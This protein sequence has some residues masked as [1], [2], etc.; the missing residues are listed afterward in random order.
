MDI[1]KY[2][3][4]REVEYWKSGR[5]NVGKGWIG[6]ACVFCNDH[7]NHLGI[8]LKSEF[9]KC[10]LC[11]EK[12]RLTK[13]IMKMENVPYGMAKSIIEK[14]G[15]LNDPDYDEEEFKPYNGRVLPGEMVKH[16]PKLHLKYL[17][18][19][20]FDPHFIIK[21]YRL[22]ACYTVGRYRFRII[23]PM[24]YN[25]RVVS[26]TALDITGKSESKYLFP[27]N[28]KVIMPRNAT[29]YNIDR[30][31][32]KI[33]IV[34]GMTD[35]WRIGDGAVGTLNKLL[36]IEQLNLIA[37]RNVKSALIIADHGAE[38]TAEDIAGQVSG[39]VNEVELLTL[40]ADD[41]DKL[42]TRDLK[43]IK[44]YLL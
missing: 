33:A 4:D 22:R 43:E 38:D 34:E 31:K 17:K 23:A 25:R 44:N 1:E 6:L 28:E 5:K 37:E 20:K 13:L 39:V 15:G 8:N 19:R 2:L 21:K 10:W 14:Y 32:D 26:F 40:S 29:L 9:F 16:F 24:I 30:V 18:R 7:S 35:V 11:S 42:N 12:G 27:S 41:P 3:E 36:S